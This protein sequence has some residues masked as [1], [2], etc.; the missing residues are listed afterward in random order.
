M[1]QYLPN[2]GVNYWPKNISIV[3]LQWSL[4]VNADKSA[5][6]ICVMS[7]MGTKSASSV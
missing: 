4:D 2:M 3:A 1:K 6:E 7:R 5:R